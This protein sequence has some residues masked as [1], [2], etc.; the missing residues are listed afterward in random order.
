VS[1]AVPVRSDTVVLPDGRH[2]AYHDVGAPRGT[3][4]VYCHGGLSAH[5]D[6]DFAAAVAAERNVRIIAAARPGI[7]DSDRLAHRQVV[8]W[9]LDVAALTAELEVGEFS[10]LGWSAGGPFA[11]ACAAAL[12]SR[13]VRTATVGGMAPLEPPLSAR[14]LGLAVDRILF[15]LAKRAR[16]LA[17]AVVRASS[18]MP[19]KTL[20]RSLVRSLPSAADR[21]VAAAMTP[22]EAAADLAEATRHGPHGI[23]DD[24]VTVGSYWGFTPAQVTGTVTLFQ[25]EEDT[26]LP[27]EHAESLATRLPDGRLE[28]VPAAGHFLLHTHLDLVL[29]ALLG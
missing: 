14:Q 4:I 5:S 16:W 1:N 29:D 12:G 3:P 18:L 13:V 22:A 10:V 28:I 15:P 25:G 9:A 8:D 11:L 2:L 17:S 21:A 23:V 7:G 26:L 6:I 27:R 19:P 20:H 24:Y